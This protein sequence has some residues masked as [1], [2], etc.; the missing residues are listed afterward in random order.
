M[1]RATEVLQQ[2]VGYFQRIIQIFIDLISS[3]SGK[4]K[5]QDQ[6]D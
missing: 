2:V 4:N 5:D 1:E 6:A 3:L